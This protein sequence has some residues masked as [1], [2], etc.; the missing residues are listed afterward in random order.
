MRTFTFFLTDRRYEVPTVAFVTA[1][2]VE[3]AAELARER[4]GESPHHLAVELRE[5]D[6]LIARIDRDSENWLR[7]EG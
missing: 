1:Q 7:A 4:L 2:D 5:N 3:R 6:E